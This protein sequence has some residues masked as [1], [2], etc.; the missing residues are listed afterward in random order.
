MDIHSV[1]YPAPKF[2]MTSRS[3]ADVTDLIVHHSDGPQDQS[4]LAIDA[5][6]RAEN[7]PFAMIGYNFV[8]AGDGTVYEGRPVGFV[9][10]AAF[11][12]NSVSIDV[13]LLGDYQPG[14]PGYNGQVPTAQLQALKD[15]S[16]AIHRQYPSIVRTIGHRD[17]ASFYPEDE[18]YLYATACPG[19]TLYAY[20][21]EV[22]KYTAAKINTL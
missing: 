17:V 15:L 9:P 16:V 6:H 20:L 4:P 2:E 21:P 1:N 11:G 14:T 13:C 12:R 3:I 5:E 7:P 22:R 8:I 19:D 18:R 10:S